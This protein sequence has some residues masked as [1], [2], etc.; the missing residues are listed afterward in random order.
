[1]AADLRRIYGAATADLAAAELEAFEEKWARHKAEA[2]GIELELN[3]A[4]V[5]LGPDTAP[6]ARSTAGPPRLAPCGSAAAAS[7]SRSW[8]RAPDRQV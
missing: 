4:D 1:M 7:R 6:A 3:I 2:E 8:S 5:E